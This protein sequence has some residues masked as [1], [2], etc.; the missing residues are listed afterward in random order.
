VAGS[1]SRGFFHRPSRRTAI[2]VL[3][4]A[5]VLC[6]V[7]AVIGV[8]RIAGA[9][10]GPELTVPG[11]THVHLDS[12]RWLVFEATGSKTDVGPFHSSSNGFTTISPSALTVT[13]QAG[14]DLQVRDVTGTQTITRGGTIFTGAAEFVVPSSGDVDITIDGVDSVDARLARPVTD[15]FKAVALWF[16]LAAL[17]F[18]AAVVGLVLALIP[19]RSNG[20]MLPAP[21]PAVPPGWYPDPRGGPL[22]RWWDGVAWT[23]ATTPRT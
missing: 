12:G 22:L 9:T 5:L 3:V 18:I 17:A 15:T 4:V 8:Q 20:P 6:A 23:D 14:D 21:V 10:D 7:F 11:T 16:G 1:A 13:D 19:Q 2:V